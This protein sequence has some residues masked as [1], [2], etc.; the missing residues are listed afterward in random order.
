MPLVVHP[1]VPPQPPLSDYHPETLRFSPR[2]VTGTAFNEDDETEFTRQSRTTHS[3]DPSFEKAA[4]Q[5]PASASGSALASPRVATSHSRVGGGERSIDS[6]NTYGHHR[7]TSIV[8]GI[9][10]SRNGSHASSTTGPLS[11]QIIAAAG[12]GLDMQSVA[13]RIEGDPGFPSR[14]STALDGP[15]SPPNGFAL[16]RALSST[17]ILSPPATQ[18]RMDQ[19]QNRSKRDPSH[20]PS[21]SR[22]LRDDQ[23]TVGE[24]ALHVL[25]TSVSTIRNL[26]PSDT[27][28]ANRDL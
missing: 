13:A 16:E 1:L 14:P 2:N 11:P 7:Q 28:Y 20:H 5:Q 25:F 10:H 15:L 19:K 3:R 8:H 9:Q 23:K 27:T 6:R 18:R 24:Y 22:Q 17:D 4:K 12:S 26:S 21:G